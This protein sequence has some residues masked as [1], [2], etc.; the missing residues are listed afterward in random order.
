MNTEAR[1]H[2]RLNADIR[3]FIELNPR[4]GGIAHNKQILPCH[5]VNISEKGLCVCSEQSLS[6]GAIFHI[7]AE[8]TKHHP[9]YFMAAEVIWCDEAQKG[10]RAGL[11]LLSAQESD[12]DQWS[13]RVAGQVT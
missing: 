12:C 5:S 8:L 10:Y 2:P 7:G 4:L 13:T 3:V 9:P 6:D 1:Q 11:K